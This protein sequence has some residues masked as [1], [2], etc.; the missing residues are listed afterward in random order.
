MFGVE[1]ISSALKSATHRVCQSALRLPEFLR[2]KILEAKEYF[3]LIQKNLRDLYNT[4]T[5]LGLYH[6]QKGNLNDAIFR[7]WLVEKFVAPKDAKLHYWLGWCYFL[8]KNYDKASEHLRLSGAADEVGLKN[9]I[10]NYKDATEV[11]EKIWALYKD[12]T[13]GDQGS[14]LLKCNSKIADEFIKSLL[15]TIQ[16]LPPQCSFLDLGSYGGIIGTQLDYH[17]SRHHDITGI[18]DDELL[19]LRMQELQGDKGQIYD[20]IKDQPLRQFLDQNKKQYHIIMGLNALGFTSKLGLPFKQ[21]WQMTKDDGYFAILLKKGAKTAWNNKANEFIYLP[22]D[23][24]EQL[25]LARF[26]ILDIKECKVDKSDEY[27]MFICK[28]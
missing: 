8:K 7:F 11:P 16:E 12:L 5:N 10:D 27:I 4:N 9:F 15:S 23:V 1:T 3:R 17:V 18:E 24:E 22:Q 6:L 25:K 2:D 19:R 28:K 14:E 26:D 20:T 13:V 21:I